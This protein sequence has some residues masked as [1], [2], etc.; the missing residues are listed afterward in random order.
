M[1][2]TV[3]TYSLYLP[4]ALAV[5]IWVAGTLFRHGRAFLLDAFGGDESLASSVNHLLIVGFYLINTGFICL[6]LKTSLEIGSARA[7]FELLADKMGIVLLVLGVMHFVNLWVF[8]RMR[9]RR[10]LDYP[11]VPATTRIRHES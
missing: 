5:T 8:R 9:R 7:V 11:P 4:L 1:N 3:L 2:H 6:F 10:Q